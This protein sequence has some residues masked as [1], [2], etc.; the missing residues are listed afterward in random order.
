[1]TGPTHGVRALGL[2]LV[3]VASVLAPAPVAG[4]AAA[5]N[6][7]TSPSISSVSLS[8]SSGNM[9]ITFDSDEKLGTNSGDVTVNGLGPNGATYTFDR[10]D[11]TKS[12]SGPYT[13][14][15]S[16]T[17]AYD[18]GD[19]TYSISVDDAKDPAGNNGGN[20]GDGSGLT[21]SYSYSSGGGGSVS[22]VS[23]DLKYVSG[24]AK[25]QSDANVE[26][27]VNINTATSS[28]S[29]DVDLWVK[30]SQLSAGEQKRNLSLDPVGFTEDTE[31]KLELT[32]KNLDPDVLMGPTNVN[33]WQTTDADTTDSKRTITVRFQPTVAQRNFQASNSPSK[34]D[35]ASYSK[36]WDQAEVGVDALVKFQMYSFPSQPGG[37]GLGTLLDG[38]RLNT[39]AQ[40]FTVPQKGNDGGLLFDVAAP[41]CKVGA[42]TDPSD[43]SAKDK[44]NEQYRNDDGFYEAVI[45][46]AYVSNVWGDIDASALTVKAKDDGT[47]ST[48]RS[49]E[50]TERA[51]GDIY[52]NATNIHYS[53]PQLEVDTDE[54]DPT[55]DAGSDATTDEGA[56]VSF[57]G[58][59]SSDGET[60]V[61]QYEWDVDGDGTY[62][63]TGSNPSHTYDESGTYTVKLRV[64]D[65]N[66]NTDTDTKTV[67]VEDAS[68]DTG[69][70]VVV[71]DAGDRTEITVRNP[72]K[73]LSVDL[74]SNDGTGA[75]S[76][77]RLSLDADTDEP[78]TMSV[79]AHESAPDSVPEPGA[80]DVGE[81]VGYVE[82]TH[83]VDDAKLS[84]V[85]LRTTVRWD[86]LT[87][88][89][90]EHDLT[91][92]R[93]HDGEWQAVD[94]RVV[95]YT[96][97]GAVIEARPPGLSVF[98]VGTVREPA[99][100]VTGTTLNATSVPAGGSV[101][102]SATVTNA[103]TAN[104]TMRVP[105]TVGDTVRDTATVSLAPGASTTVELTATVDSAGTA[106]LAVNGTDAGSVTVA[107]DETATSTDADV[108]QD[109]A[110]ST[111]FPE[112]TATPFPTP[113]PDRTPTASADGPGPGPAVTLLAVVV[114]T[115]ALVRRR[116]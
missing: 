43:P 77:T 65:G 44:C 37:G 67:T 35:S 5:A 94:T 36:S 61:T 38:A 70:P 1:M 93:Y 102:V 26:T 68:T 89:T 71:A 15:L 40:A 58:T 101:T 9:V 16:T 39:D 59:D 60:S 27:N 80:T 110:D 30:Q 76:P 90:D 64:T 99:L 106:D 86:A 75:V 73:G 84:N 96:T 20:S 108:G 23:K 4:A 46:S 72:S 3:V 55:A 19:G 82:V 54:T 8:E 85:R 92:Y 25:Y 28:N 18:D 57:D 2:A 115:L 112:A 17:Q 105:L 32:V 79:S 97:H 10:N 41:H 33:S 62:E 21:D 103:G 56:A 91:F 14:T 51:N 11:F 53:N 50:V 113:L 98:A 12:G 95:E 49:V 42:K 114:A 109:A 7:T 69:D 81:A 63:K 47:T 29:L 111:P 34:W 13:Y 116:R 24:P 78:F 31:V 83:S 107:G 88:G 22:V 104:G 87:D 100:S 48:I 74:S 52:I 66:S 45:P 6:D